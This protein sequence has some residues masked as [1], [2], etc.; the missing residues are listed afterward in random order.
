[1]RRVEPSGTTSLVE[2]L[3]TIAPLV[4]NEAQKSGSPTREDE[5][6]CIRTEG[7][8]FDPRHSNCSG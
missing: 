4:W 5:Q 7:C 2:T 1:M 8:G 6:P 3:P